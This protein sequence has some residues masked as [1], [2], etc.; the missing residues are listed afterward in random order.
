LQA[1]FFA[2]LAAADKGLRA[3]GTCWA[4]G[5]ACCKARGL[6]DRLEVVAMSVPSQ[7][8]RSW[9]IGL[10]ALLA[11]AGVLYILML[12]NAS[13]HPAGGGESS[14]AAALEA[15]YLT[16]ALWIVLVCMLIVGGVGGTMPRWAG[17]LAGILVPASGVANIVAVDMCSRHMP[18]AI[19]ILLLLAPLLAFY[20]LWARLPWLKAELPAER[21]S[22]AVWGAVFV[23]SVASYVLAA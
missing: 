3:A 2:Q 8:Q 14:I 19:V 9:P 18:W 10:L 4:K 20:A 6:R 16:A 5:A 1:S 22:V 11:V 15:L 21:I 17:W 12:I 7:S 23:L 13:S